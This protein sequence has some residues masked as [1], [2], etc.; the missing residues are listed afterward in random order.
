MLRKTG[1]IVSYLSLLFILLTI[2]VSAQDTI[3][4]WA[5]KISYSLLQYKG[6]LGNQFFDLNSRNDGAGIG[7]IRYINPSLDVVLGV[8][9]QRLGF[10]GNI[11]TA[12]Y[13]VNG[14]LIAPSVSFNY[15]FCN[16][17]LLPSS[18]KWKP[19]LSAGFAYWIGNTKGNSYDYYG[20]DFKH[21][22][23]EFAF[24]YSVGIK[25]EISRRTS[26]FLEAG[27]YLATTEEL[28][29]VAIDMK[30]DKFINGRIGVIIKLG[31]PGDQDR[32]GVTDDKDECPDTPF[33]V[34]VDEKGC[35]KD[36]DK[37]GIPDYQ[38][39][40]PDD[41]GL[42]EF[43]G[44]PDRDGDG[45]MD[46]IDDCPDLPGIPKYN[47]CPDSDGDGVIDPKDLCPDTQPGIV[48]DEYGC[49]IDSDGDGLTDDVDQCPD[50]Y[51]PMEYLGCPEP[52]EAEWP[53]M[54]KETPPE[55]YFETDKHELDPEAE[56]ELGEVV[57][58]MFE[59]PM[60][61]IR[62]YGFA[63]P[64]GTK[65]HNEVLSAR[66]VES[67]KKYLM[68]KGIPENRIL[69]RALGEVQEVKTLKGEE[70]M[71]EDQKLKK[72][73]KVLFETFFFYH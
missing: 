49:P 43:N 39:D 38:D 64:R 50:E 55:V 68:R 13:R 71:N 34:E 62:L 73:R 37:D 52:P 51:G 70:N 23:D 54:N 6:E 21:F 28:D 44:C 66:R 32:D 11:D 17:Y 41:P 19:W 40:C 57:K 42:P 58:F 10:S 53:D 47:G 25:N 33:G 63:D 8:D 36:R 30:N 45:I 67:V 48:V 3:S 60:M 22:I 20:A 56:E 14:N 31:G 26:I 65:E 46:K 35:P 61:N 4:P 27:G 69:I 29:G 18:S 9:Y 72:Y 24:T 2:K 7:L 59:N 1:K 5:L 16:D 12:M 15:K